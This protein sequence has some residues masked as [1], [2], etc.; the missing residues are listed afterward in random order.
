MLRRA[1]KT[2][3]VITPSY[4]TAQSNVT[5]VMERVNEFEALLDVSIRWLPTDA[6]YKK[7]KT[8]LGERKYRLALDVV[9]RLVVQRLFELE[10]T[11]LMSTGTSKRCGSALS[12]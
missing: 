5:L 2:S 9:E 3:R 12:R 7:A 4:R 10:K 1:K 11:H 8:Y 6:A